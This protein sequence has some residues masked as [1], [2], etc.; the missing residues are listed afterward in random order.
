MHDFIY[1]FRERVVLIRLVFSYS[2]G[3][4]I[5]RQFSVSVCVCVHGWEFSEENNCSNGKNLIVLN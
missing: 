3:G 5:L 2:R 1:F 4:P